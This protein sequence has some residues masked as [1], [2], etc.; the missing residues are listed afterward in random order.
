[1]STASLEQEIVQAA[2]STRE[3]SL[4][5]GYDYLLNLEDE[6]RFIWMRYLGLLFVMCFGLVFATQVLI[7]VIIFLLQ[8]CQFFD[9]VMTQAFSL[10]IL[11]PQPLYQITSGEVHYPTLLSWHLTFFFVASSRFDVANSV[12]RSNQP[13]MGNCTRQSS[14]LLRAL[15]GNVFSTLAAMVSASITEAPS[16]EES[17]IVAVLYYIAQTVLLT[18]ECCHLLPSVCSA[19]KMHPPLPVRRA[20]EGRALVERGMRRMSS[21]AWSTMPVQV[22]STALRGDFIAFHRECNR[23]GNGSFEDLG[24]A[25]FGRR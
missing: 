1:M 5:C 8:G 21:E 11:A 24:I 14:I 17:F 19:P 13:Y 6:V 9:G 4:I 25:M 7:L 10:S 2:S 12:T 22:E 23:N 16:L 15:V 20:R 3:V 18:M